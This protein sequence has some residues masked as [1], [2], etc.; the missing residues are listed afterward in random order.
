MT[1]LNNST[2]PYNSNTEGYVNTGNQS[3]RKSGLKSPT[4]I[5]KNQNNAGGNYS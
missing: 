2:K 3:N 5:H 1:D 4:N